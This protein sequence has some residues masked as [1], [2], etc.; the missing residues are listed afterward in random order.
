VNPNLFV[1][2]ADE[3]QRRKS[4]KLQSLHGRKSEPDGSGG[5]T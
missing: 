2:E 4:K 3:R 1:V 5:I